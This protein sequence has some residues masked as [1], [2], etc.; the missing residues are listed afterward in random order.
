MVTA[1]GRRTLGVTVP[2]DLCPNYFLLSPSLLSSFPSFCSLPPFLCFLS[3]LIWIFLLWLL[4]CSSSCPSP[5][6]SP[7]SCLCP[8]PHFLP[9]VL[10]ALSLV[11]A[12]LLNRENPH[13]PNPL[14]FLSEQ[15]ASCKTF[16]DATRSDS[17]WSP[18]PPYIL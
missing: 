14:S 13:T 12:K 5:C 15:T 7:S 10:L 1:L 4:L 2:K 11:I 18:C 3:T 17:P 16:N 9:Q 8:S 6:P